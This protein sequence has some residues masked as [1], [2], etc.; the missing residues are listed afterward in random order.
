MKKVLFLFIAM[1]SL[2]VCACSNK[3]TKAVSSNQDSINVADTTVVDTTV[4]DSTK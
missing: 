2:L 3:S 4:V 1:T